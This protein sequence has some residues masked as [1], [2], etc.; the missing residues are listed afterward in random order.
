MILTAVTRMVPVKHELVV[1]PGYPVGIAGSAELGYAMNVGLAVDGFH[2]RI[3]GP[4]EQ[5]K[6]KS[7]KFN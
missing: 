5:Y 6:R 7:N 2:P 1:A 4:T 3:S